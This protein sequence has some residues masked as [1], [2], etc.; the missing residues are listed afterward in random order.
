[1]GDADLGVS[2]GP[3]IIT[4]AS[5]V[6][7][8]ECFRLYALDVVYPTLRYPEFSLVRRDRL[9]RRQ[10]RTLLFGPPMEALS[11]CLPRTG[12][13]QLSGRGGKL[14]PSGQIKREISPS[15]VHSGSSNK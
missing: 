1:M 6:G 15:S 7:D 12:R 14:D 11:L 3:K 4:L 13:A 8:S 5:F 9:K 2:I 10:S